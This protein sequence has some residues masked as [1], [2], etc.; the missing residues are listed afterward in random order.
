MPLARRVKRRR[1]RRKV[2]F[3]QKQWTMWTLRVRNAKGGGKRECAREE[4][5]HCPGSH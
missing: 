4:G 3:K 5:G 2:Y 1:R